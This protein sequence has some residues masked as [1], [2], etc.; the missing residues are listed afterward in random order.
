MAKVDDPEQLPNA[1]KNAGY[2]LLAVTNGSYLIFQGDVFAPIPDCSIQSVSNPRIELPLE[3]IGR[4]TGESEYLDNAFNTGLLSD[5][6]GS[7]D[8]YL[9]IRDG[10][11]PKDLIS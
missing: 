8:L 5:F 11:E 4:G 6:T 3:T 2:S 10:R 1:L 9:T 7:G